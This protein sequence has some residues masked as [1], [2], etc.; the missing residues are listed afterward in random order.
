[1]STVKAVA[2]RRWV[3]Q[4]Y[5]AVSP[6]S[7]RWCDVEFTAIEGWTNYQHW[8]GGSKLWRDQRLTDDFS[9]WWFV[10]EAAARE[11]L[12]ELLA[13]KQR[14]F[15]RIIERQTV[16]TEVVLGGFDIEDGTVVRQTDG[17]VPIFMGA[18]VPNM[19]D[20]MPEQLP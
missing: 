9:K 8:D 4:A 17:S 13:L 10:D 14:Y 11:V 12:A 1:M 6:S 7:P 3:L 19:V 16:L 18:P 20:A 5:L 15:L 2:S